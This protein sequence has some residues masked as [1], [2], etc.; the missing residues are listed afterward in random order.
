MR[1]CMNH[2][3]GEWCFLISF[4]AGSGIRGLQGFSSSSFPMAVSSYHDILVGIAIHQGSND[5][6]GCCS[7][8]K[9]EPNVSSPWKYI[10]VGVVMARSTTSGSFLCVFHGRDSTFVEKKAAKLL[11]VFVY[12][13]Q[14]SATLCV[15]GV[16]MYTHLWLVPPSRT[17]CHLYRWQCGD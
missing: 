3:N 9:D 5:V 6:T 2:S 14:R 13:P 4:L 11:S 17:G 16:F 8:S 12:K 7:L 15:G 1:A 10:L